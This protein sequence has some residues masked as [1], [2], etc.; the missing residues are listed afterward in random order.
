MK[1][2]GLMGAVGALTLAMLVP[3]AVSAGIGPQPFGAEI[4]V[5]RCTN[6]NG[7]HGFG[8]VVLKMDAFARN[9]L[10]NS[11]TPNYIIITAWYE[12]KIDGVWHRFDVTTATGPVHPDGYPYVF[13]N[14]LGMALHFESADHPRT[15]Q[16]MKVEFFD[17]LPTGDV[18]LGKI[19]ARTAAC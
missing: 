5:A 15:R 10:A 11:P 16:V 1:R 18:R 17:D 7:E 12:Q 6:R 8:K 13:S 9:D 2:I 4:D 19:T 3:A 14:Y